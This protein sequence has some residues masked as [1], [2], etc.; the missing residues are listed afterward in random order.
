MLLTRPSPNSD[1]GWKTNHRASCPKICAANVA[2]CCANWMKR[3]KAEFWTPPRAFVF[4][5][6]RNNFAP[7][8]GTPAGSR[9]CGKACSARSA[10]NT[11]SGRCKISPNRARA[12]LRG[13]DPAF[14]LQ[15]RLLGIS[16]LLPAELTARAGGRR[17][18]S[19]SRLWDCWWRERDEFSDCILPRAVWKFHGLR[20]ANHPQRRLALAA[21]W[22][23]AGN[24][25][26]K[27]ER[28]CA[29]DILSGCGSGRESALTSNHE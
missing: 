28:W 3:G 23:A 27:L 8:P 1:C 21:H 10:T 29:V 20:P 22:L 17:W 13:A 14:A 16:G 5:P 12:G 4:K 18:L 7:A 15:A 9:R 25:V 2:W 6:R 26:S 19:A 11:T 24:L